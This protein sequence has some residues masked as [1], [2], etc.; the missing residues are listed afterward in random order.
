MKNKDGGYLIPRILFP[1]LEQYGCCGLILSL[2]QI[3]SSFVLGMEI[4]DTEFETKENTFYTDNN[5]NNNLLLI[6]QNEHVNMIK[7]ALQ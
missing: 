1:G 3:L 6:R 5:N 4:Y 7:C 2:V